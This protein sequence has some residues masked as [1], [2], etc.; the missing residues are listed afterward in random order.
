MS[1]TRDGAERL[2]TVLAAEET[3]YRELRDCLQEERARMLDLD[4]PGLEALVRRKEALAAEGRLLD[5]SRREV[6]AGL[7][8]ALGVDAERPALRQLCER[9][10]GPEADA[11]RGAHA[12][13]VALLG[14]VRELV[15]ANA[16]VTGE[17]L[18]EVQAS[19]RVLGRLRPSEPTY[20]PAGGGDPGAAGRLLRRTA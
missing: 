7:A 20:G 5:E 16:A 4:G 13:L 11:L 1:G 6:A 17:A 15:Q 8:A 2:L 3:L 12:R 18:S 10:D 14:S 19:L 9:L